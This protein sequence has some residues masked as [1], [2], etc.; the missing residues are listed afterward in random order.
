[1]EKGVSERLDLLLHFVGSMPT[2]YSWKL[3]VVA[4]QQF[5]LNVLFHPIVSVTLALLFKQI[6]HPKPTA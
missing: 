3:A 4:L 5:L 6:P 2:C 1:M